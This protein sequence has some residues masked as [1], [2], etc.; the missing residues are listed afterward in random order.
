MQYARQAKGVIS[1][2]ESTALEKAPPFDKLVACFSG[3]FISWS[4]DLAKI[5]KARNVNIKI[6]HE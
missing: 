6:Y 5:L 1:A 2:N 3:V 4:L